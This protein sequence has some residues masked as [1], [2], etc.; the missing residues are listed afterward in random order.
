MRLPG[1]GDAAIAA[2]MAFL[3]MGWVA[4]ESGF[5]RIPRL[6]LDV[7]TSHFT[8]EQLAVWKRQFD[9]IARANQYDMGVMASGMADLAEQSASNTRRINTAI[10]DGLTAVGVHLAEVVKARPDKP[11]PLDKL[12]RCLQE[13]GKLHAQMNPRQSG[14]FMPNLGAV[15]DSELDDIAEG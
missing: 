11:L 15:D 10:E 1:E 6:S 14:D 3:A 7:L 4:S 8:R 9:W 12:T 2:F 5:R 13:L